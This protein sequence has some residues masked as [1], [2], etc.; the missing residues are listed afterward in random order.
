[1]GYKK[2]RELLP[3]VLSRRIISISKDE[4]TLHDVS[5]I[6]FPAV[7]KKRKSYAN[8]EFD[9]VV[10][11][12]VHKLYEQNALK[13]QDE[14]PN[15]LR[16]K[17]LLAVH[18]MD[19]VD[20]LILAAARAALH[21]GR[22]E[23]QKLF[24]RLFAIFMMTDDAS[25]ELEHPR[26]SAPAPGAGE[27]APN[28]SVV[29]TLRASTSGMVGDENTS[30]IVKRIACLYDMV[31]QVL[32]GIALQPYP[33]AEQVIEAIARNFRDI[34]VAEDCSWTELSMKDAEAASGPGSWALLLPMM[35][36]RTALSKQVQPLKASERY[37]IRVAARPE[38][39]SS[40]ALPAA[41]EPAISVP[42]CAP[43]PPP[44]PD[45]L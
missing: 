30:H 36:C 28:F 43:P 24:V 29:T 42:T 23:A 8:N 6:A 17:E 5:T 2:I 4:T 10:K 38:R 22:P 12:L 26:A 3:E 25:I 40:E 33:F 1:M 34:L 11:S 27:A 16:H 13:P 35:D 19:L 41:G 39:P 31:A 37:S 44:P 18:D 20:D 9:K 7:S 45:W 15:V 32:E 21:D 14:R